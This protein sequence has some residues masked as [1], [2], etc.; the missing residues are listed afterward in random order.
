METP[1][2]PRRQRESPFRVV[3]NADPL[4]RRLSSAYDTRDNSDRPDPR[5]RIC[6]AAWRLPDGIGRHDGSDVV[7]LDRK[8][9]RRAG[10]RTA[11]QSTAPRLL[12]RSRAQFKT[13]ADAR[14][15]IPFYDLSWLGGRQYLRGYHSYRFRGNN[16]LLLSTELQQTVYSITSVRG[17]DSSP[18]RMPARS[19]ARRTSTSAQLAL[20][21][22]RRAA[23]PALAQRRRAHRS[24]PQSRARRRLRVAVARFLA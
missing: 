5:T 13:P 9:I 16:V 24:E 3:S 17:V 4:L 14:H 7:W 22:R 8:G 2:P 21:T 20:R 12:L 10:I 19:G 15:Q 23:V 18:P 11:R 6:S 1:Q